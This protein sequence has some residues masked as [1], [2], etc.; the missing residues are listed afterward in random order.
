MGQLSFVLPDPAPPD[1]ARYLGLAR[2]AGGYDRVPV[3][4]RRAVAS[5]R[6]TFEKNSSDSGYLRCPWPVAGSGSPVFTSATLRERP[7]PYQFLTELARGRL[8]QVRTQLADWEGAGLELAPADRAELGAAVRAF[9][10]AVRDPG[11]PEAARDAAD[12][13]AAGLRLGD[14]LAAA[15]TKL[16]LAHRVGESGPPT[17]R[18]GARVFRE[19]TI[20]EGAAYAAAFNAVRLVPRW[21][22]IEPTEARLDWKGFDAAVDWAVGAGLAVSAGPVIDLAAG[23]FP[24]WLLAHAGDLTSLTAFLCEYVETTVS[25]YRG[26][27]SDWLVFSG[28]NHADA[29]GL[30][31]DDRLRLAARLV[32][33]ARS[34]APG[35]T[36]TI[37]LSQVWGDYL[38]GADDLAYSPLMFADTLLRGGVQ[39]SGLELEVLCGDGPRASLPRTLLDVYGLLD[40]YAM[41][42]VPLDVAL[43]C[44]A[45]GPAACP[46][47]WAA[48]VIDLAV[49]IG[50][51]SGVYWDSWADDAATRVPGAPLWAGDKST[52][53]G[54]LA[55]FQRVRREVLG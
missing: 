44:P 36:Y 10:R 54:P 25:T 46:P 37:G 39:V 31:E 6:L 3:A 14:R 45:G 7:E 38:A 17:T 27:V 5:R 29:L 33:S 26:R 53:G 4:A 15:F 20:P 11:T 22:D 55:D 42:G 47:G 34:V 28:F 41:L 50:Q 9:G 21:R 51:V 1:A 13:L 35:G 18:L 23:P 52:A 32:E 19:P 24:D 8:N 43:S 48:D 40:L 12:A 49:G 2:L 16:L 30:G